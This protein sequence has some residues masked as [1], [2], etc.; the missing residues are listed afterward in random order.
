MGGVSVLVVDDCPFQR[1]LM[2]EIFGGRAVESGAQAGNALRDELAQLVLLD[3]HL[4]ESDGLALVRTVRAI[5][6]RAVVVAVSVDAD[7]ATIQRAFAYGV[8]DFVCKSEDAEA[9][10][11]EVIRAYVATTAHHAREAAITPRDGTGVAGATLAR[12][13]ARVP[14]IIRSAIAGVHIHGETGTGKEVVAD[15][16]RRAAAQVPFL[17][18][19]CAAIPAS[20][21]ESTL[22]G[23]V[24]GAFT[25]AAQ[26][27]KGYLEA[28]T[29]GWIF[30]DEVQCLSTSAQA[31]LLRAIESQ[32]IMRVGDTRPIKIDV[33]FLSA[34]NEPLAHLVADGRFRQDLRQRLTD[35]T[36][37]LPPLRERPAEIPALIEHFLS[38]MPGGPYRI[39][40]AARQ[41]LC[42]LPWR[43]GNVREL[44]NCLR[45]MTEGQIDGVLQAQSIPRQVMVEPAVAASAPPRSP[46]ETSLT[47]P[48]G[49]VDFEALTQ[50]LFNLLVTRATAEGHPSTRQLAAYL[51]LSKSA[52]S[53]RLAPASPLR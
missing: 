9:F 46:P 36:I 47:I 17:S 8:D 16:F 3:V 22:F 27:R 32:E 14:S 20:L 18:V 2:G 21:L 42:G 4:G 19:N 44:R 53:R 43:G 24:R 51:G 25:G 31:A 15:L 37:D 49:P 50:T 5:A 41:I 10:Y 34:A 1:E 11:E 48:E 6:P 40:E 39:A 45:A 38:S 52:V 29:G 12:I 26:D 7:A 28:A 13:R 35:A 23:A 33:R 30:L